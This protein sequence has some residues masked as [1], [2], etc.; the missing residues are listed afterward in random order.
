MRI[1][2]P[3]V[4]RERKRSLLQWIVTHFMRT[5]RPISSQ[6][7]AKEA[8]FGLSSATIRNILQELEAE[9]FLAQPHA[10]AGRVP[11]DKGY[12]FYVDYL[13]GVQ[14]LASEEKEHIQRQYHRRV[15]ELDN[16]LAQ[17]SRMLSHLSHAAAFVL[18]PKADA[19][20]VR[21]LELL[22]LGG[23]RVLVLLVSQ[24]GMVRHWPIQLP[25][26]TTE[27]RL[28]S[29]N[30]CLNE[31]AVG[32]SIHDVQA[33][34]LHRVEAAER[35][36]RE[37]SDLAKDI[38]KAVSSLARP[39]ELYVEGASRILEQAG[40]ADFGRMRDSVRILEEKRRFSQLLH[41][42][43]AETLKHPPARK[44]GKVQVRIGA[45]NLLPELRGLSLITTTYQLKDHPAGVLGIVGPRSMRYGKMV[46]LVE[47]V[48]DAVSRA[49]DDWEGLWQEGRRE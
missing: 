27:A 18:S 28:A 12:R 29:L 19:H 14:R 15:A 13:M 25:F 9:G 47:F 34:F 8:R 21:R 1:L 6:Q 26:E 45:E 16:L 33:E 23:R 46:A 17:T 37:M 24:S 11:T 36:F 42:Q 40:D 31:F 3:E 4:A 32:R 41:R 22:P 10:S 2:D 20:E 49:L 43:L 38:L 35:E 30:R 7:I 44:D 48:S 39:D 5:S